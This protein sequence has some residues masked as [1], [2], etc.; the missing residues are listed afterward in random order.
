MLG[1]VAACSAPV[2]DGEDQ[3]LTV[4]GVEHL[5]EYGPLFDAGYTLP[6]IPLEYT[7]GVNRRMTGVYVG[8][9]EPY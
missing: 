5:P 4:P 8:E 1:S 9:Q 6:P 2:E 3:N 7:Q